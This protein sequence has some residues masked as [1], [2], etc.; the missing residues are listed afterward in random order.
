MSGSQMWPTSTNCPN[1][2]AHD[3]YED[4]ARDVVYC[5]QCDDE[6]TEEELD[7]P[8]RSPNEHSDDGPTLR[9]DLE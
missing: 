1:N 5:K 2:S 6:W 4:P 7:D 8:S 9:L 3:T